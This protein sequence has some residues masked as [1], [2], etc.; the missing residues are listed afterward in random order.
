MATAK[1]S[2]NLINNDVPL[3]QSPCNKIVAGSETSP[4]KN[5][6]VPYYI[7]KHGM[8]QGGGIFLC[9]LHQPDSKFKR[10]MKKALTGR[11]Q[12]TVPYYKHDPYFL[13]SK[14][15]KKE[16]IKKLKNDRKPQSNKKLLLV[17]SMK[18]ENK[19]NIY[20]Y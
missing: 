4:I 6:F 7:D 14:S 15:D 19:L 12:M 5:I 16:T 9:F 10:D 13:L 1:V 11:D 17:S 20:P 8:I 3:Y 2:F 18:K